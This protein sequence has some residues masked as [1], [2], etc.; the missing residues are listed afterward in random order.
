MT[1]DKQEE[2]KVKLFTEIKHN[3]RDLIDKLKVKEDTTI[4][5]IIEKSV[6]TYIDFKSMSPEVQ[7]LIEKYTKIYGNS[8]DVIEN[9]MR[10]FDEQKNPIKSKDLELWCRA[11]DELQTMLIGKTTF[12]QL[13]AAAEKPEKSLDKPAKKNI[14]LDIILW[15]TGKSIKSLSLKEIIDAIKKM[16]KVANYFYHIEV[17]EESTD[18]FHIV[19]KHHEGKRFSNYWLQYFTEL[20]HSEDLNFICATEG[21]ALGET[22]SL[23]VK[24]LNNKIKT[25]KE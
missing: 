17:N 21:E 22:L 24:L 7:A 5:H 19:F 10:I 6:Q 20:F 8:S 25:Q 23:T 18:Q 4:G 11:R 1:E 16:W 9:A 12:H 14:G 3:T 2:G 13:L 15:V